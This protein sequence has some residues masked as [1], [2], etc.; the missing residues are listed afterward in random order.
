LHTLLNFDVAYEIFTRSSATCCT[1]IKNV[2][3]EEKSKSSPV[4][5]G[6]PG[7]CNHAIEVHHR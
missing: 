4:T 2:E 7:T 3:E 1:N 6:W 5:L